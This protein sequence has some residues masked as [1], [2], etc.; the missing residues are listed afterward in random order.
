MQQNYLNDPS[1][2]F[3]KKKKKERNTALTNSLNIFVRLT[4]NCIFEL[5]EKN[6]H[7][8]RNVDLDGMILQHISLMLTPRKF[9]LL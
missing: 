2:R 7:M 5:I 1:P 9:S 3:K 8:N 4:F 6:K